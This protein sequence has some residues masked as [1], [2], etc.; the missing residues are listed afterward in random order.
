MS[1][2]STLSDKRLY[3]EASLFMELLLGIKR[4]PLRDDVRRGVDVESAGCMTGVLFKRICNE[5]TASRAIVGRDG[6]QKRGVWLSNS[7]KI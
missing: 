4:S 1:I 7:S 3:V 2:G 5:L 6:K